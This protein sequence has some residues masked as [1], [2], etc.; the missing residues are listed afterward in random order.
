MKTEPHQEPIHLCVN[1]H[2]AALPKVREAVR[3]A[4]RA[5]GFDEE[6][7]HHLIL[8]IDEAMANVIKHGYE[9]RSDQPVEI[10]L[11]CTREAQLVGLAVTIRDYGRQVHPDSIDGRPLNDVRPGGLGVHI[12]RTIMDRVTYCPAEGGG[13]RL[14][15]VKFRKP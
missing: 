11:R 13:M 15:M 6:S 12:I 5:A 1:S 14:E 9:G 4:A 7:V 3:G 8:A 2:A 10:E